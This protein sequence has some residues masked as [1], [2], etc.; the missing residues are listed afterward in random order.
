MKI[1]LIKPFVLVFCSEIAPVESLKEERLEKMAEI[2]RQKISVMPFV[3]RTALSLLT[4]MFDGMGIFYG[5]RLF[6][7]QAFESQKN[8]VKALNSSPL[9]PFKELLKFYQK[10][11]V[12]IYFSMLDEDP[13]WQKKD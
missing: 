11:S 1:T 12:F 5:A 7:C 6:R 3:M 13:S 9:G 10:M 8:M 2:L 4:T